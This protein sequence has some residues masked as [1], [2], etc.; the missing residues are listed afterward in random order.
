MVEQQPVRA[1]LRQEQSRVARFVHQCD[2]GCTTEKQ[3]ELR[4]PCRPLA[5]AF[6]QNLLRLRIDFKD[7]FLCRDLKSHTRERG[8]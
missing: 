4:M 7:R 6:R 2:A 1:G 8:Q 3:P 5:G